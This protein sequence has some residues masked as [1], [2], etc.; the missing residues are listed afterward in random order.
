M[1]V[2]DQFGLF[3]INDCSVLLVPVWHTDLFI[4]P[5]PSGTDMASHVSL[6]SGGSK[7]K[8]LIGNNP[9]HLSCL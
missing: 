7:G 8:A 4:F 5:H 3:F 9:L 6:K 1:H 2:L